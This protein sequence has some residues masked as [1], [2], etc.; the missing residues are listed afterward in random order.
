MLIN[1]ETIQIFNYQI[2]DGIKKKN[3]QHQQ[4]HQRKEV[5]IGKWTRSSE[6][7]EVYY[8]SGEAGIDEGA[9]EAKTWSAQK[10]NNS[11]AN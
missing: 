8:Q 7:K 6:G 1:S 9:S 5:R 11:Y 3:Q 2:W 10:T 4:H